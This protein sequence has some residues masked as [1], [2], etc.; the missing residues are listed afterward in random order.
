[1]VQKIRYMNHVIRLFGMTPTTSRATP[2]SCPSCGVFYNDGSHR[3]CYY[4]CCEYVDCLDCVI[5]Q[6]KF[7]CPVFDEDLTTHMKLKRK[8]KRQAR[9]SSGQVTTGSVIRAEKISTTTT[10]ISA[11]WN[12]P[13]I[14]AGNKPSNNEDECDLNVGMEDFMDDN[15]NKTD[16][17]VNFGE[18]ERLNE[19]EIEIC[20]E[21]KD[22]DLI[23][24][25]KPKVELLVP[26]HHWNAVVVLKRVNGRDDS[27]LKGKKK[28]K[29][30]R[31][32]DPTLPPSRMSGRIR[33]RTAKVIN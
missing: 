10:T 32:F 14:L 27:G 18:K 19:N 7:S 30:R 9:L 1:M 20:E 11:D 5:N 17:N 33:I 6:N 12:E 22:C 24:A 21:L 2:D 23:M 16:K 31:R 29:Y 3:K 28:K 26:K 13:E 15:N 25:L 4:L 8:R